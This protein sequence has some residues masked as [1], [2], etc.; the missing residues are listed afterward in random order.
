MIDDLQRCVYTDELA[1]TGTGKAGP[2][3]WDTVDLRLK[4]IRKSKANDAARIT[5]YVELQIFIGKSN[6]NDDLCSVF[7]KILE[8]DRKVYGN[9]AVP[10]NLDN[11]PLADPNK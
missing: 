5:R 7:S 10:E 2:S 1:K 3:Y 4:E 8:D 11:V 9:I 6:S